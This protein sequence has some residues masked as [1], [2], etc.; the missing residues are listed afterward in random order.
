MSRG[1][2]DVYKRQGS[3][4]P[5]KVADGEYVIA[6]DAVADIGN[7]STDAGAKKLDALMKQVRMARHGTTKQPPE[8]DMMSVMKRAIT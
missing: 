5:L 7:G 2:G 3:G 8:K 1:L 6:A 4:Q